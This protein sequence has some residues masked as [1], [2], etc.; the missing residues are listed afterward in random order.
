MRDVCL[1]SLVSVA[2]LPCI[3]C[4]PLL[5]VAALAMP[6]SAQ[7]W[8]CGIRDVG[9]DVPGAL[10][11]RMRIGAKRKGDALKAVYKSVAL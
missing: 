4:K 11:L 2:A 5:S 10:Q 9:A 3:H 7:E 1:G 8:M 6:S